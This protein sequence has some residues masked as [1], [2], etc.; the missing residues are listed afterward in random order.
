MELLE[1][2]LAAP[3]GP[4]RDNG[5]EQ[6]LRV[7]KRAVR[8]ELTPRQMQCV[9]LYYVDEKSEK[10][11]AAQLGITPPTVSKHL[12]KARIHLRRV[13]KYYF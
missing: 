11:I 12:K 13:M 5:H 4:E 3:S 8:G 6:M 9:A 1:N 10:A 7:L 2:T